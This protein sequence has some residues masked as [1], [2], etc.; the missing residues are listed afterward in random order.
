MKFA[1]SRPSVGTLSTSRLTIDIAKLQSME[2]GLPPLPQGW[3]TGLEAKVLYTA[4]RTVQE[5]AAILEI[6]SWAGRSSCCIAYG[7][8]DSGKK[9]RYDIVDYGI[10]GVDEW[11]ER[12]GGNI[13][14]YADPKQFIEVI[15]VPGGTA[16]V[17]KQNL[18]DRGLAK[19]VS[20]IVLGDLADYE[21][22]TKY[23]FIFCD[24]THGEEEI[25][26]NIPRVSSLLKDDW[27]LACDDIHTDVEIDLIGKLTGAEQVYMTK[28]VDQYAKIAV[29]TR[30]KK[31]RDFLT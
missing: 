14:A 16:A 13:F 26:R 29:F 22:R 11:H 30:G 28:D 27:I 15:C 17:L 12:F 9:T 24:T 4:T 23:D 3:L 6:G 8:R 1:L 21:T 5:D 18:I 19:Y 20:L 31:Y 10:A 7:V 2:Q 25:K